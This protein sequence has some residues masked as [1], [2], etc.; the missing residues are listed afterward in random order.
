MSAHKLSNGEASKSRWPSPIMMLRATWW[1]DFR[2]RRPHACCTSCIE[3]PG[4][5]RG[6]PRCW[7]PRTCGADVA[8]D[9]LDG[10]H[11]HVFGIAGDIQAQVSAEG[12]GMRP[13]DLLGRSAVGILT[14]APAVEVAR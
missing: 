12:R 2:R 7:L 10:V 5:V 14:A 9:R 1:Q 6:T 3:R 11:Q 13:E 4:L 8:D